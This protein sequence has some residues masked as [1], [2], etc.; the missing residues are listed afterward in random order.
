MSKEN[1]QIRTMRK[2]EVELAVSWAEKEGW[3][4]GKNDAQSYCLADPKGFLIGLVEGEPVAVISAIKY[5]KEFG[6]I[7]FYIVKPEY[8]GKGYGYALWQAAM[9]YLDGCNVGLDGVV[10]QQDNYRKSGFELAYRNIRYQGVF[11]ASQFDVASHLSPHITSEFEPVCIQTFEAPFFPAD[12]KRFNQQWRIQSN[13]HAL[14]INTPDGITGYGVIRAC[15][16]GYK[17]GPL[18]AENQVDAKALVGALI[19]RAVDSDKADTVYLDVPE[20]NQE[21]VS[22]AKSLGMS[23]AFETAR[24]YTKSAP[25]LPLHRMFGVASF[26]IG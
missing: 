24:M 18:Y 17:I 23:I 14:V 19:A 11:K 3:N 1:Y 13:A 15:E 10:E 26:E 25:S 5:S 6:F 16:C 7:G 20:C 21:A 4:P 2:D 9:A 8:R 22:M 12:R